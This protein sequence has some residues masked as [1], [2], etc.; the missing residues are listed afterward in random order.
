MGCQPGDVAYGHFNIPPGVNS[1]WLHYKHQSSF[2][3]QTLLCAACV[4]NADSRVYSLCACGSK[5]VTDTPYATYYI[6]KR[7]TTQMTIFSEMWSI[8]RYLQKAK[9]TMHRGQQKS[10]KSLTQHERFRA[11]TSLPTYIIKEKPPKVLQSLL[12]ILS[13]YGAIAY[14]ENMTWEMQEVSLLLISIKQHE[15]FVVSTTN[16]M[17]HTYIMHS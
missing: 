6:I 7:K 13:I 2:C 14:A 10:D 9:T 8:L 15:L 3:I 16:H 1:V 11:S 12:Q 4:F 5:C 17:Q